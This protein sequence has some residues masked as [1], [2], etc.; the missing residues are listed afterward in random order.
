MNATASSEPAAAARVLQLA[1]DDNIA[2][3]LAALRAG[4][5]VSVAGAAVRLRQDV[6][7]GHKF[8]VRAIAPDEII[9]KYNC[10]I[11]SATRR[12]EPGEYV[13]THNVR[14]NYL[15]NTTAVPAPI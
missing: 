13:H 4:E 2:V 1:P 9:R 10:P 11:G 3:A 7:V 8:A 12:I 6:M 15:A 14:S 5:C